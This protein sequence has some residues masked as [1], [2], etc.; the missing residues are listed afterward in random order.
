M[1]AL[2]KCRCYAQA[3][4]LSRNPTT[5]D[6][7]PVTPRVGWRQWRKAGDNN[8]D[9]GVVNILVANVGG[10]IVEC[11]GDGVVRGVCGGKGGRNRAGLVDEARGWS[12]AGTNSRLA[13]LSVWCCCR[14]LAR[15][16]AVYNAEIPLGNPDESSTQMKSRWNSNNNNTTTHSRPHRR[17]AAASTSLNASRRLA[18][19]AAAPK[20]GRSRD[21]ITSTRP[22]CQCRPDDQY[23]GKLASQSTHHPI[24]R[25]G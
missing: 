25:L 15:A 1:R 11:D 7:A 17:P 22:H 9:G 2:L 20:Q 10:M 18:A 14:D 24:P 5:V 21:P 23:R 6:G 12:A 8:N 13:T 4:Q 19:N 16:T 3:L